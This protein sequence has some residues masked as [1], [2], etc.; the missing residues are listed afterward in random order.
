MRDAGN[1]RNAGS[2]VPDRHTCLSNIFF[3]FRLSSLVLEILKK[4]LYNIYVR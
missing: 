1:V 2:D 4:L 3:R